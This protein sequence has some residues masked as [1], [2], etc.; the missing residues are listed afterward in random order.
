[1]LKKTDVANDIIKIKN[2][3]ATNASVDS[4]LNDLKA[5]H[6]S[7]EVKK[8]DDKTRKNAS[9]IL[10]FEN[11]LKQKENENEIGISFNRGFFFT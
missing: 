8:I 7:T 9:D 1:M 11:R 4:K 10:A 3:Y 5:Q 2:D 6:I